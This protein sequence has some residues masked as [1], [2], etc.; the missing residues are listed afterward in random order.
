MRCTAILR[1]GLS[2]FTS[3]GFQASKK[4]DM[5]ADLGRSEATVGLA[6]AGPSVR[7][8]CG[9]G[10]W[11][12][13]LSVLTSSCECASVWC[14]CVGRAMARVGLACRREQEAGASR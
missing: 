3:K 4:E 7:G 1:K 9:D 10:A 14:V 2:L 11:V 8:K 12:S 5:T 6:C 13:L